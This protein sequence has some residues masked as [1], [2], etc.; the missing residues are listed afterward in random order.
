MTTKRISRRVTVLVGAI[1]LAMVLLAVL[2]GRLRLPII[3]PQ[4]GDIVLAED[5]ALDRL[6][7]ASGVVSRLVEGPVNCAG[8]LVNRGHSFTAPAWSADGTRMA[9]AII[10]VPCESVDGELFDLAGA[11]LLD[12]DNGQPEQLVAC[13]DPLSCL[14]W[15]AISPDGSLMAYASADRSTGDGNLVVIGP[16]GTR[17][18]TIEV[19]AFPRAPDFS[20]DG[21]RVAIPARLDTP[22]GELVGTIDLAAVDGSAATTRLVEYADGVVE[23]IDWSPDGSRIVY[24][25]LDSRAAA[26]ALWVVDVNGETDPVQVVAEE[27]VESVLTAPAWSPDGRSITYTVAP[28]SSSGAVELWTMN[29]DGTQRT[30]VFTTGDS[31][32]A[33][34]GSVWSPDGKLIAFSILGATPDERG[35]FL[36]NRVGT[37][38]RRVTES[39]GYPIGWQPLP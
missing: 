26:T 21:R 34:R 31:Y 38:L 32:S 37:D 18:V 3:P 13:P 9:Y 25:T 36:I 35:V 1:A 4:N 28:R 14:G 8:P 19:G 22:A 11:W 2:S 7:P 33:W 6:N 15:V 39:A 20:P 29:A 12:L 17:R 10:C 5:C 30:Q 23:V 16:E 24:S 27:A